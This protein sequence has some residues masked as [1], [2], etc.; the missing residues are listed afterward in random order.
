MIK[1]LFVC[2]GS[3]VRK[4]LKPAWI[5]GFTASRFSVCTRFAP[6]EKRRFLNE[7]INLFSAPICSCNIPS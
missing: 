3:A 7:T 5:L 1:V 6:F 2:W 4:M